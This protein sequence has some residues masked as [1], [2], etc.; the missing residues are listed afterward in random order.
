MNKI[1][2]ILCVLLFFSGGLVNGQYRAVVTN[3]NKVPV[4]LVHVHNLTTNKGTVSKASGAFTIEVNEGDLL[5]IEHLNY[6][7]LLFSYTSTNQ[8]DTIVL[9]NK[10]YS[11][12]EIYI[13]NPIS[14]AYQS[15]KS[16]IDM[17]PSFLG[18][19][20][21]VKY[22]ATL[23]GVTSPSMLDA[24]IYVRGGNSSQN[25]FLINNMAVANPNH[26]TGILST[27]D[28]YILGTSQFYKSGYPSAYNGYLS[29]YIN[30]KPSVYSNTQ[31]NG[32][33]NA[34]VLS[35]SLKLKLRPGQKNKLFWG[36]SL[37]KSYY[38]IIARAYNANN[39]NNIPAYNFSDVT[40]TLNYLLSD[41]WTANITLIATNDNLPLKVKQGI[42]YGLDWGT[43][44]SNA[45]IKGALGQSNTIYFS[46]GYNQYNSSFDAITHRDTQG[47]SDTQQYSLL[48]R[49]ESG[50]NPAMGLTYG[51][52][53]TRKNYQL[54][55]FLDEGHH[56]H[57]NMELGNVFIEYKQQLS[58]A[59]KLIAGVNATSVL[60]SGYV[61]ISPRAKLIYSKDKYA[62]WF[63]YADTRQF[64]E[65]MNY[66]TLRSPVDLLVPIT[67]EQPSQSRQVSLGSSIR[68]N[69]RMTINSGVFY[70]ELHHI[71]E[72]I[73]SDG[74]NLN[75]DISGMV[76]G[77]G[78]SYGVELDYIYKVPTL[79]ARLNYTF[80]EVK[81]R[82][83]AIN[84]GQAFYPQYD[85]RHNVLI[86][87]SIKIKNNL[88]LN[89]LWSYMS[90]VTATIPIGVAIAKDVVENRM[91]LIPVY[92]SRYNYR[93][94]ASHHLDMN[95]EIRRPVKRGMLK[96]DVGAYNLYNQQNPSFVYIEPE[97]KDDYFVTF[98]LKSKVV[99][100]FMPYLSFTYVFNK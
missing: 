31:F 51:L 83:N 48:I 35:S 36:I 15:N 6:N 7:S 21:V 74:F 73:G 46:L 22:L 84:N 86:N 16:K 100:P 33:I 44:S 67:G 42:S 69:L 27:F 30:M 91:D 13:T 45:E 40:S 59:L 10:D 65:R 66:F 95:L 57:E 3:A 93:L 58:N 99:L 53:L 60:R 55:Q 34:G 18:E 19:Q 9:T 78:D 72:F 79:Y 85:V 43:F 94:P 88:T 64:E 12:T 76:D 20:D 23:P 28:P 98:N 14:S 50:L 39:E 8:A 24:G 77:K 68:P 89:V 70:K 37:R 2:H 11:L 32:E 61:Y 26:L 17:V 25:A 97:A 5:K 92:G 80:S 52:S 62:F 54:Y 56:W 90:G 29:S 47:E 87:S 82:F 81:H 96:F 38:D 1:I 49:G 41:S 75:E 4:E 63:D 71:K